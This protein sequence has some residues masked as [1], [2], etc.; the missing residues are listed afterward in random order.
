MA[1]QYKLANLLIMAFAS[2]GATADN[3]MAP[4]ATILKEI[5]PY[6]TFVTIQRYNLE[7]TGSQSQGIN[8][9]RLEIKFSDGSKA[10]LPESG[11]YWPIGQGQTQE[12]N[13]TFEIPWSM[14]QNDSTHFTIQMVRSGTKLAPCEFAVEQI[15]QFNRAYVCHTDVAAQTEMK[16][17][18]DRIVKESVQIRVFSDRNSTPNEIPKDAI[19]LK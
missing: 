5:K 4:P 18:S 3:Q 9:S 14:I 19:A 13:R 2:L 11:H 7:S 10:A 12:V 16:I 1:S 8:N 6:R 15:S 17:P